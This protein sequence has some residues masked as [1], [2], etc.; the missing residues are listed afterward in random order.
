MNND[1]STI[2]SNAPSANGYVNHRLGVTACRIASLPPPS[3]VS[4]TAG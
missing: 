1:V 3:A 4:P 2:S